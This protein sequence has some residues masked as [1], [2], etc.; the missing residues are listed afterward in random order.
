MERAR[1]SPGKPPGD[2]EGEG[3]P[4]P[5]ATIMFSPW[6]RGRAVVREAAPEG[7][8]VDYGAEGVVE[9][10]HHHPAVVCDQAEVCARHATARSSSYR[11]VRAM[12]S[13]VTHRNSLQAEIAQRWMPVGPTPERP[14]ILPLAFLDRTL[15]A[16]PHFE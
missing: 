11:G 15:E 14:E 3:E 2:G 7:A 9:I 5:P 8:V 10:A 6:C 4:L 12:P 16:M 13:D 1:R